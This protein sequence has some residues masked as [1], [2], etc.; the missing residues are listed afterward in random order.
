MSLAE[1]ENTKYRVLFTEHTTF[2]RLSDIPEED[3]KQ[4][5]TSGIIVDEWHRDTDNVSSDKGADQPAEEVEAT[6]VGS[7]RES[8]GLNEDASD[9]A[10]LLADDSQ[11]WWV[12]EPAAY[13]TQSESDVGSRKRA[14]CH[15]E[16]DE[17]SECSE[18]IASKVA[19]LALTVP[20][21][22]PSTPAAAPQAATAEAAPDD[23]KAAC[24]PWVNRMKKQLQLANVSV[25]ELNLDHWTQEVDR[26]RFRLAELVK[27]GE[28]EEEEEDKKGG[29]GSQY[30][31]TVFIKCWLPVNERGP[32]DL[33]LHTMTWPPQYICERYAYPTTVRN[34]KAKIANATG[35]QLIASKMFIF[36]RGQKLEHV[37]QALKSSQ[38]LH[39]LIDDS[40]IVHACARDGPG[41]VNR[42][43]EAVREASKQLWSMA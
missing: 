26:H 27:E 8:D 16:S 10:Q 41:T 32:I 13:K 1:L 20:T 35:G 21:V 38:A 30:I 9:L 24:N 2:H 36:F 7:T 11:A 40:V 31:G 6:S 29:P 5:L 25:S 33:D 22:P 3:R 23:V 34:L 19:R 4:L 42:L 15:T 17:G 12:E 43:R 14:H 39:S 18:S 28:E 37:S